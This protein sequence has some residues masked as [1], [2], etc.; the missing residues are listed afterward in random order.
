MRV[1]VLSDIHGFSLAFDSVCQDIHLTGPFD[2]TIVAGDLCEVGPD[3]AGV[4]QRLRAR[5]NWRVLKGNTDDDLVN[6]ANDG[7]TGFAIDAISPPG[8]DWLARLPFAHRV[9]APDGSGDEDDSLLV[10]H[11]NPRDLRG[12]LDPDASDD[13]LRRLLGDARFQTLAFGHVHISYQRKLDGRQLVDVSAVGN[14]KDGDLRS[15]WGIFT[16]DERSRTWDSEIRRVPY[17]LEAT[18]AQIAA[19]DLPDPDKVARVLQRAS[20]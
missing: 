8:V 18:L 4:L 17:P 15:A 7:E 20:Y 16:W 6:A 1:A 5:P 2:E 10:V 3:P 11:A 14:P 12:R 13:E 19:S 9:P